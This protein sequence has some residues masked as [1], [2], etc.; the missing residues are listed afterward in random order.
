MRTLRRYWN[1]S[2]LQRNWPFRVLPGQTT[3]VG[4]AVLAVSRNCELRNVRR[5]GRGG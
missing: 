4:S 5:H 2:N 1:L 3:N